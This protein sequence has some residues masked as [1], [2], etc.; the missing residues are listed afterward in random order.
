MVLATIT[1]SKKGGGNERIHL[2][3]RPFWWPCRGV[4]AI[5]A[6][7]PD[8][9]CPGLHRKPLGAAIGQLLAPYRPGGL[10]GDIQHNDN[11]K[12]THF[13]G[14]FD[15]HHNAVVRYQAHLLMEEVHNFIKANKCCHQARDDNLV[16]GGISFWIVVGFWIV[17]ITTILLERCCC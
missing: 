8:E 12:C 16:P 13:A 1:P 10:Q 11:A 4:E 9:A 7:S 15:G 17:F 6:A 14:R 2:H 3:C 5:H